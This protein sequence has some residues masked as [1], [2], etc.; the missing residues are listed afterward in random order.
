M[1]MIGKWRL[2]FVFLLINSSLFSQ[3]QAGRIVY[4]RKTNLMKRF[5]ENNSSRWLSDKNKIKVDQFE[6]YFNDTMSVFRPLDVEGKDEMSWATNKNSVQQN[7]LRNERLSLYSVWGDPL[8]VK[9]TL[10]TRVWKITEST[11]KIGKYECRKAMWEVNDSIRIYAWY[12][13]EIIP[14]VGPET[15]YGLPG[16]ILGVASED[17]GVIYFAKTVEVM[18]PDFTKLELKQGKNKT[19]NTEEGFKLLEK[20]F[21][22]RPGSRDLLL[23]MFMW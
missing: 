9:D 6:L 13:D 7:L 17:G 14:S 4:E 12:T 20:Q 21:G 8:Y 1:M 23:D 11:R 16:A 2:I 15:F 22:N 5:K 3:I 19:L 18:Q 10:N